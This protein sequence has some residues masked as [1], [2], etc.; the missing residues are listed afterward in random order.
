MAAAAMRTTNTKPITRPE[1]LLL[2]QPWSTATSQT[3]KSAIAIPA[4]ALIHTT[5]LLILLV[6]RSNFQAASI[7]ARKPLWTFAAVRI[8]GEAQYP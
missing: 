3:T 5:S 4:T 6:D 8:F 1:S 2:L 7:E